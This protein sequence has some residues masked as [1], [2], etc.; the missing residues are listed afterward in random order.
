MGMSM[1][2]RIAF[3]G[4]L[5]TLMPIAG[6]Q[7]PRQTPL[8]P[9][10]AVSRFE[11]SNTSERVALV[12]AEPLVV[13][14]V[15]I[16]FDASGRMWVVEMRD[17]PSLPEGKSPNG[18]ISVVFDSD[19]DGVLDKS[20]VFVDNLDMPTGLA[21]WKQGALVTLAGELAYFPDENRDL[22]ADEKQQWLAGFKRDNE[23]LRANHPTLGPDGWWYIACGLRG[24]EIRLGTHFDPDQETSSIRVGS[25]DIRF[26]LQRRQIELITGPAQFGLTFSETGQRVF[27]SNRNPAI[28]VCFE[29]YELSPPL[30]N[31]LAPRKDILPAGAA[32]KVFPLVNAWTTSNLHANQ[33]TAACGVFLKR[34]PNRTEDIYVCEPTGSL[35]KRRVTIRKK[36]ALTTVDEDRAPEWLASTDPWCRPVNVEL[37][38][39]GEIAI[40]DMHRAVIE[41]P[42]WVPTELKTRQDERW[43]DQAGRVFNIETGANSLSDSISALTSAPISNYNADQ[44]VEL[45]ASPNQWRARVAERLIREAGIDEF[46]ERLI[47]LLE[48]STISYTA[49]IRAAQMLV[50]QNW[51]SSALADWLASID[52]RAEEPLILATLRAIRSTPEFPRSEDLCDALVRLIRNDENSQTAAVAFEAW[53]TLDQNYITKLPTEQALGLWQSAITSNHKETIVAAGSKMRGKEFVTFECWLDT[54]DALSASKHL[55]YDETFVSEVTRKLVPTTSSPTIEDRIAEIITERISRPSDGDDQQ[56]HR[57]PQLTMAA[58]HQF[59]ELYAASGKSAWSRWLLQIVQDAQVSSKLRASACRCLQSLDDS[60]LHEELFKSLALASGLDAELRYQAWLGYLDSLGVEQATFKLMND[61]QGGSQSDRALSLRVIASNPEIVDAFAKMMLESHDLA[62]TLGVTQLQSLR[63][64]GSATGKRDI[65]QVLA[66]LVSSD[67]KAIVKEFAR[68]L[69][70]K[71]NLDSGRQ[72]F[73]KHCA[74]CHRVGSLGIDLGPDISDSRTKSEEQL[75]LS[76]LDPNAA[77]DNNYFRFIVLTSDERVIE[78]C[79]VEETPSSI[80]LKSANG[81]T[82]LVDRKNITRIRATGKSLMPEGFEAELDQQAMADLIAFIKGWRYANTQIPGVS[83]KSDPTR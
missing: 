52:E 74:A 71:G 73:S 51:N 67:R 16:E 5:L 44:L 57:L 31:I 23:Q 72:H 49:R 69:E 56:P 7:S 46:Q 35:I 28:Q 33:F 15:D 50:S 4:T 63:P 41:H 37:A 53:L 32:S 38:P 6:A 68:C 17:Y 10:E 27:C 14:P 24:G 19:G 42:R 20:K 66:K 60:K 80:Y 11:L 45:L 65:E 8:P 25:R 64:K 58:M 2:A 26:S 70:M 54:V 34:G 75:L 55:S 79:I 30:G 81:E 22:R 47:S 9:D 29:Q 77:V 18:R 76:I 3:L 21:L 59:L 61:L 82:Q 36:H 48:S 40:V 83:P 62:R 13:D 1:I 43:G 12:A 78:G 39:N